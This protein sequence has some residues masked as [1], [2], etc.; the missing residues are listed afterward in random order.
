[1]KISP[2]VSSKYRLLQKLPYMLANWA[3]VI[4]TPLQINVLNLINS[5]ILKLPWFFGTKN[6]FTEELNIQGDTQGTNGLN[7]IV[8]CW[9]TRYDYYVVHINCNER[10]SLY[11][12]EKLCHSDSHNQINCDFQILNTFLKPE[13]IFFW[14]DP[15]LCNK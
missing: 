4:L 5:D 1:M 11:L 15:Y 12:L 6:A 2:C 10:L 7:C 3:L 14:I 8:Q 9:N 13:R